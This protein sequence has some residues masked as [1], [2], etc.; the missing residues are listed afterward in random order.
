[1]IITVAKEVFAFYGKTHDYK[2][3]YTVVSCVYKSNVLV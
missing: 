2:Q 3:Y 1:M